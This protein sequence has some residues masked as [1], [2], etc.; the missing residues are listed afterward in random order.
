MTWQQDA[1]TQDDKSSAT[2]NIFQNSLYTQMPS[3][4]NILPFVQT[5]AS[6][7]MTTTTNHSMINQEKDIFQNNLNRDGYFDPEYSTTATTTTR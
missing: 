6:A 2:D 5:A 3:A 1:W 7:D 4:E